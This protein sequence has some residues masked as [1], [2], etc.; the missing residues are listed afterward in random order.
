MERAI[1]YM[2][3]YKILKH[4]VDRHVVPYLGK[5]MFV[6]AHLTNMM[7]VKMRELFAKM[8]EEDDTEPQAHSSNVI[9]GST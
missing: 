5:I 8:E 1:G 9:L 3:R 6:C 4:R 7:P 2:K